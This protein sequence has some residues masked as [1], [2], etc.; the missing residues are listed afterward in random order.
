MHSFIRRTLCFLA[1]ALSVT[2]ALFAQESANDPTK[3]KPGDPQSSGLSDVR[4]RQNGSSSSGS[5]VPVFNVTPSPVTIPRVERPPKLEDFLD[6]KPS[7]ETDGRLV[8]VEGF[9]QRTPRDGEPATQRTEVY[10]GY[11]DENLYIISVAFDTEPDKIR[12]RM[13]RREDAFDDDFVE[14]TLDTFRDQRRGYVFWSNPLGIQAEALWSEDQ[15]GPDFSFDTLWYSRGQRTSQGYVVWMSIPFKSLRFPSDA[16]QSWGITILRSIPRSDEWAYWPRVSSRIEGR[17][18]QAGVVEGLDNISPGRNI[19]LIPY[20]AFRSFRALDARDPARPGFVRERADLDAGLDA[21]FVLKDKLV[22]DVAVNPDF[23]QVESDEPQTTVNQRFEVFFPEKRPFFLENSDFFQT[24]INLVFTRRIADPQLGVRLTG[25]VG[26]YGIGAMLIDDQSPGRRVPDDHPFADKRA[27]FAVL[28][29]TR[30]IFKQSTVGVI[31]T[32]REFDTGYNRVGGIDG[33]LKLDDH[34]V[35]RFQAT[36]SSTRFTDGSKLS[37]PAYDFQ[38]SRSGRQ[39]N[40]NGG[41]TEFDPDF[42]TQTGFVPRTDIRRVNQNLNYRFRP[43][44]KYLISW[45]PRLT[46]N[47]TWD[48]TGTR[49]DWV[50]ISNLSWEFSGQNYAGLIYLANRERLRPVDFPVLKENRDFASTVKGFFFGSSYFQQVSIDGEYTRWAGI[51][52]VPPA[53]REPFLGDRSAGFLSVALR[54]ATS[55]RIDNTYLFS[56][57]LERPTGTNIFNNHIIRSKW[58]W[59][60]NRELSLRV[61]LEYNTVLTNPDLTAIETTKNF[62]AD[63]LIAY[64]VNAWTSLFVGYNSNLQNLDL[65]ETATGTEITRPR[66]RLIN[67]GKQFFVKFSYLF[68]F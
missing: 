18:N 21:K 34:W 3:A 26:P 1:L 5:P 65:V 11:D 8:K 12:A 39:L 16:E 53:G 14:V 2:P 10:L 35:A 64:Q 46:Y 62:N 50:A 58:N 47:R 52:F 42:F 41:Y 23:S 68:R 67:D 9:V 20:G 24:P 51:N 48:H 37:G 45:G 6:M 54:P 63:F 17:L 43:E 22:L 33:R 57:L 38:V 59:Q 44:G 36:A 4:N 55:L 28:R 19:Q 66:N 40:Y 60:Y 13:T 61:I 49:L 27:G 31:Y 7:G 56:R 32:D 25:K 15:G 30:D 29:V